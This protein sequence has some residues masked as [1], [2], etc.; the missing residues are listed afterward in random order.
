V[1]LLQPIK[2]SRAL[3]AQAGHR[4]VADMGGI[5]EVIADNLTIFQIMM[6]VDE[7]IIEGL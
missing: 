4:P 5:F 1:A 7:T 2:V 6:I 3:T